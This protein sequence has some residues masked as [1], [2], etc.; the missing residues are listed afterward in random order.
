M[1]SS[2]TFLLSDV[3]FVQIKTNCFAIIKETVDLLFSRGD[4]FNNSSSRVGDENYKIKGEMEDGFLPSHT[5][6]AY[7]AFA[8]KQ[9]NLLPKIHINLML[10]EMSFEREH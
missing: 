9:G 3:I 5:F 1:P 8:K 2:V 10:S 6:E 4:F 7:V